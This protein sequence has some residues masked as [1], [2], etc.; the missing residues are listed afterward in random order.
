MPALKHLSLQADLLSLTFFEG[1]RPE[2]LQSVLFG[3]ASRPV[4]LFEGKAALDKLWEEGRAEN[5]YL[6]ARKVFSTETSVFGT[7]THS[8]NVHSPLMH[9][10]PPSGSFLQQSSTSSMQMARPTDISGRQLTGTTSSNIP[11]LGLESWLCREFS[12][13][14]S[15]LSQVAIQGSA[16]LDLYA[17]HI[18]EF[19]IPY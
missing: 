4:V 5:I 13:P 2:K 10:N 15:G 9:I 14:N 16:A 6:A 3:L 19:P 17:Q 1:E 7:L 11:Q 18:G 8:M 12:R